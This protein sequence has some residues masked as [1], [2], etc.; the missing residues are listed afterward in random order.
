MAIVNTFDVTKYAGSNGIGDKVWGAVDGAFNLAGNIGSKVQG[1]QAA[2]GKATNEKWG[3][4]FN[5]MKSSGSSNINWGNLFNGGASSASGGTSGATGAATSGGASGGTGVGSG[6]MTG[7][8]G[9]AIDKTWGVANKLIGDVYT[10]GRNSFDSGVINTAYG[11]SDD[12]PFFGGIGREDNT[13]NLVNDIR[14]E[15]FVATSNNMDDLQDELS[16]SKLFHNQVDDVSQGKKVAGVFQNTASGA[17]KGAK[18]GSNF[19][20]WGMAIGAIAGGI[21]GMA[22]R[23]FGN[24]RSKR[25]LEELN[26]AIR[27]NNTLKDQQAQ[28]SIS[29]MVTSDNN[30][31][32]ANMASYGGKLDVLRRYSAPHRF[33]EGGEMESNENKIGQAKNDWPGI[34]EFN[35]GGSHEENRHGGIL[36]GI[37]PD[38]MPN[39]V[40][41]GEVKISDV[42][43]GTNPYVLSAR[44]VITPET[45]EEFGIDS[46]L[47][48]LSYAEAFKKAY[49][50]YKERQ[51]HPEVRNEMAHLITSFQQAQDAEKAKREVQQQMAIMDSLSPEQQQMVMD[52]ASQE[53]QAQQPPM[54]QQMPQDPAQQQMPP[55]DMPPEAMGGPQPSEEEMQQMA[56][57]QG[58]MP[59]EEQSMQPMM[60]YGGRVRSRAHRFDTGGTLTA[61]NDLVRT[62]GPRY[63]Y[64]MEKMKPLLISMAQAQNIPIPANAFD[65]KYGL[66]DDTRRFAM[67]KMYGTY[68]Q[69]RPEQKSEPYETTSTTDDA[70]RYRREV[71]YDG[72]KP[73][74][75]WGDVPRIA[76]AYAPTGEQAAVTPAATD[77]PAVEMAAAPVETTPVAAETPA[78][79]TPKTDEEL[80]AERRA[81]LYSDLDIDNLRRRAALDKAPLWAGIRSW[82]RS[83]DYM[84][85]PEKYNNITR[86]GLSRS[87]VSPVLPTGYYRPQYLDPN[88]GNAALQSSAAQAL[89]NAS[90]GGNRALSAM[91]QAIIFDRAARAAGEKLY[92]ARQANEEM[93]GKAWQQNRALDQ[94]NAQLKLSADAQN[95][96][97]I[98]AA[99]ADINNTTASADQYNKNMKHSL[100]QNAANLIG[101]YGTD[102]RNRLSSAL[103]AANGLFGKGAQNVIS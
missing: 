49:S 57:Q 83:K 30:K 34:T 33:A 102:N 87:M 12:D 72:R 101:K 42:V 63:G 59:P 36:Q 17:A 37:A 15:S 70:D 93:R 99:Y 98:A 2:A 97:R 64:D 52:A 16:T 8:I 61:W 38:G 76:E 24:R 10:K 18:I 66:A 78:A 54:Q 19:G 13:K 46:K 60:A 84:V 39:L 100:Y 50:P 56:M 86:E 45:A 55:E 40:E 68:T 35:A 71:M 3:Q 28:D 44:I 1:R 90:I 73:Q 22:S 48:G 65:Q 51:G 81:R 91:S 43:G 41:Q 85:D 5:N 67:A 47:V 75:N 25:R 21:G 103:M 26:K 23:L 92:A 11:S 20:P 74:A 88:F 69:P 58:G 62:L 9:N 4:Y 31:L 82:L 96:A 7:A 27:Y 89:R 77:T 95:A 29:N 32:F 80:A 6:M 79:E 94:A 53:A 14:R